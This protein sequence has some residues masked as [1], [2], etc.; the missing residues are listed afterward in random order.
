MKSKEDA[1]MTPPI[2][3]SPE[4]D[5]PPMAFDDTICALAQEMKRN[6]LLWKP[7]IG[8]FVWDSNHMKKPDAPFPN[9]IDLGLSLPV[10]TKGTANP[11]EELQSFDRKLIKT[12][13][14]RQA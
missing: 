1:H 2:L 10:S 12:L 14:A 11:A 4:T 7:H 3:F 5:L 13:A 8:Y 9:R 6:G